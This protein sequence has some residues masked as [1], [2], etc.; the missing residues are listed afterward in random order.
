CDGKVCMVADLEPGMTIRVT[1]KK[2]DKTLALRIEALDKRDEFDLTHD[3]KVTRT[4]GD[5]LI[6][7]G[8]DSKEDAHTLSSE[9]RVTWDCEPCENTDLRPGMR[10]RVTMTKDDKQTATRVE[11]LDNR[12]EFQRTQDGKVVDRVAGNKWV[13]ANKD[14]KKD[15]FML[16]PDAGLSCD[17]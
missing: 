13:I 11:A 9:A 16:D 10:I 2:I 7:S 8:T 6:M 14:G 15:V 5:Q 3:G 17:G 4:A 12:D 1:R